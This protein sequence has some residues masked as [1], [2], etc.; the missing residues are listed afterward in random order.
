MNLLNRFAFISKASAW[1]GYG[2]RNPRFDQAGI[3]SRSPFTG[4]KGWCGDFVTYNLK[5]A[6]VMDGHILNRADINGEWVPGDNILRLERWALETNATVP[7]QQGQTGDIIIIPLGARDAHIALIYGR[8]QG[9]YILLN[10]NG[11]GGVVSLSRRKVTDKAYM[12]ICL[13]NF[14][15]GNDMYGRINAANGNTVRATDNPI[16][17]ARRLTFLDGGDGEGFLT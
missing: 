15:L 17:A 16:M 3:I 7:L 14:P 4:T 13:L 11:W 1:L 6:G 8:D 2:P 9:D 10:G 12:M 5:E